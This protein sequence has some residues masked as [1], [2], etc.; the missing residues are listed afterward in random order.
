MPDDDLYRAQ[1]KGRMGSGACVG[2]LRYQRIAEKTC[3]K[4]A[5]PAVQVAGLDLIGLIHKTVSRVNHVGECEVGPVQ[6]FVLK[7][8]LHSHTDVA[9]KVQ[10]NVQRFK[11]KLSETWEEL[12]Y[13]LLTSS[14]TGKGRDEVLQFIEE[15]NN[16]YNSSNKSNQHEI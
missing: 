3:G 11:N 10:G 13:M 7:I 6:V 4:T 8:N 9:G 5:C 16:L 15:I 12:P 14:E 2:K 1:R